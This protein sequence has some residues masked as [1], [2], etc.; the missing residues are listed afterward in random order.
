M[1]S[2]RTAVILSVAL[3]KN[4][5]RAVGSRISCWRAADACGAVFAALGMTPNDTRSAGPRNVFVEVRSECA[6]PLPRPNYF[7]VFAFGSA[8]FAAAACSFCC[9]SIIAASSSV[10]SM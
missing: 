4:S 10:T 1:Q 5:V 9:F 8:V 2:D 6:E 3:Q 7:F